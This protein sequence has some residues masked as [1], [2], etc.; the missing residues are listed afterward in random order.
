LSRRPQTGLY[1]APGSQSFVV[2]DGT[3]VSNVPVGVS[4][5]ET[6]EITNGGT[7]TQ[8]VS[9]VTA[10]AGEFTASDLPALGTKI[11]PAQSVSI[12]VTFAPQYAGPAA[13]SL[14]VTG[15][16]GTSATIALS[17]TGVAAVSHFTTSPTAVNF[18]SVAL[19]KKVKATI[20][21][22]NTGNQPAIV[23][24]VTP[25]HAP[26]ATPYLVARGLPVNAGYDLK[27]TVTFTPAKAGIFTDVYKLTWTD[28][29]GTHTVSI[30]L[31]GTGH[32]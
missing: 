24:G 23:T 31:T 19:G 25:L 28:S 14:K 11:A 21:I 6:V 12:L 32:G 5:P 22:G 10:P 30:P 15:D 1:A 18:G 26:F 29:F 7:S 8:T 27:I 16:S 13:G 9:S 3:T 4:V 17:G 20:H 2:T